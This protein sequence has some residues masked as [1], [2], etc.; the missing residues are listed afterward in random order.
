MEEMPTY[1]MPPGGKMPDLNLA[2]GSMNVAS[3]N[4]IQAM[5]DP[6]KPVPS[7]PV[8][9]GSPLMGG[10]DPQTLIPVLNL[11]GVEGVP[12]PTQLLRSAP[13][14]INPPDYGQPDFSVPALKSYDLTGPGIDYRPDFQPD[15]DI[16]N[17][18]EYRHPNG[19]DIQDTNIWAIDPLLSD[20]TQYEIP[21]GITVYHHPDQPDPS[22]PDLQHPQ[23]TQDAY[24]LTRPADLADDALSIMHNTASY[25]Q[26]ADKEY[27][28]A[29]MDQSGMNS[30]RARHFSLLDY[31]LDKVE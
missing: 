22:L 25:Q 13:G 5:P 11:A 14:T 18:A 4:S 28:G 17:L 20:A 31:G 1:P 2:G 30:S 16:P 10:I 12:T 26:V 21:D 8:L 19:L 9:S 24:M 29:W 7:E 23:L 15:P 6:G 27:P 3:G